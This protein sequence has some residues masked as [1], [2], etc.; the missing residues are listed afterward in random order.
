MRPKS[1]SSVVSRLGIFLIAI[2]TIA[3]AFPAATS[4]QQ[5]TSLPLM[6]DLRERIPKP[7]LSNVARI[8]FLTTVDFP[9][10]NFIDQT[11]KLS[12]FHVDLA[13]EICNELNM[14]D[15]CQIEAVPFSDLTAALDKGEGE[16][17][18]AG[19]RITPDLRRKDAFSRPFLQLPARFVTLRDMAPKLR[20]PDELNDKDIG[21]EEGTLHQQML[22]AFF[23][24]L[25]QKPFHT[26]HDML[27]ALKRGDI[28]AVFGDGLQLS[29]W[30]DTA[31]A[32]N[33]CAF[34]GEPYFSSH[35]FGE[36]MALMTR[37]DAPNLTQ[38]LDY[39]LLALARNGR[40]N[41]LYLRYFPNGL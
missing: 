37:R 4:E 8:R 36:G 41:T 7:D 3:L 22:T 11:G 34:L 31:D 6:F 26:R 19:I 1:V 35:F 25:K 30:L 2:L 27:D 20:D 24:H 29:F 13:R 12:G 18:A 40:L 33:C 9:P 5:A 23:P 32:G 10:F 14:V 21:V 16:V 39:A 28:A 38:A 15:R 17:I